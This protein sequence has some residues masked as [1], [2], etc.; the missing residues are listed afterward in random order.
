MAVEM[1]RIVKNHWPTW[2]KIS[3]LSQQLLLH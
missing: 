1:A 2:W 3:S